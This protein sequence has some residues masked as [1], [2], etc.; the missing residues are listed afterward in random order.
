MKKYSMKKIL[1][2]LDMT[3][4]QVQGGYKIDKI[5][6]TFKF[7]KRLFHEKDNSWLWENLGFEYVHTSKKF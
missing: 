2:Q 7:R 1:P 4:V 3:N 5:N 6:K